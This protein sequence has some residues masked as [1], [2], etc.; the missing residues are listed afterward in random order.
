MPISTR[1]RVIPKRREDFAA[2]DRIMRQRLPEKGFIA[3][4]YR[5][6]LLHSEM[7]LEIEVNAHLGA[8]EETERVGRS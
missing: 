8:L 2:V 4:A 6:V 1:S 3:H 5:G 7:D